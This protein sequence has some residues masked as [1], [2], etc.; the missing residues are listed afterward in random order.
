MSIESLHTGRQFGHIYYGQNGRVVK[1]MDCKSI[2]LCTRGIESNFFR[3]FNWFYG[4]MDSNLQFEYINSSSNL[5]KKTGNLKSSATTI[6]ENVG[7]NKITEER[8][9]SSAIF[10]MSINLLH[11][12]SKT[13]DDIMENNDQVILHRLEA[14]TF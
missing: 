3:F 5:G 11:Y 9:T 8:I 4:E 7:K 6:F 10:W 1:A 14:E 12:S 2:G 13:A